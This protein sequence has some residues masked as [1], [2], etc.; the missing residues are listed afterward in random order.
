[1]TTIPLDLILGLWFGL[2]FAWCAR[3]Q[4]RDGAPPWGRD[5]AAVG[6][7]ALLGLVPVELYLCLVHPDWSWMYLVDPAHLGGG[8]AALVAAALTA[9]LLTGWGVGWQLVK[10]KRA[11]ALGGALAGAPLVG[12]AI[13]FLAR[14][15]LAAVGS[16]AEFHAGHARPLFDVKLGWV[17]CALAAGILAQ[18]AAVSWTLWA[19]GR[20][21]L[22]AARPQPAATPSVPEGTEPSVSA[23]ASSGTHA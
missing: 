12:G 14:G 1:M 19:H 22:A 4:F 23:P 5:L 17:L 7:F 18:A 10:R 2:F 11:A 6:S 15:R 13:A 8:V 20:R 3:A 9:A 16:F 21:A